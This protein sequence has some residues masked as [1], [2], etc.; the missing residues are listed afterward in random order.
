MH[1]MYMTLLYTIYIGIP[2]L[3]EMQIEKDILYVF[4]TTYDM[5]FE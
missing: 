1:T 4:N 3:I 5:I 2:V